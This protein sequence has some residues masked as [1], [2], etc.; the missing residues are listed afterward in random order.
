MYKTSCCKPHDRFDEPQ[1]AAYIQTLV[2]L[3]LEDSSTG[4]QEYSVVSSHMV[5]VWN[6]DSSTGLQEYSV[7]SSHRSVCGTKTVLPDCRSTV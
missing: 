1:I 7:V 6:E 5:S 2:S 4:L 3:R